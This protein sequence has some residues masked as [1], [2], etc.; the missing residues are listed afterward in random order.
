MVVNLKI[1]HYCLF[2][3]KLGGLKHIFH[4]KKIN[5]DMY[6]NLCVNIQGGRGYWAVYYNSPQSF[7]IPFSYSLA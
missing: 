1:N 5:I 7:I 6:L 3:V 4:L 2:R